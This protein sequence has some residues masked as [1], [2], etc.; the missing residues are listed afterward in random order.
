MF[1]GIP[2]VDRLSERTCGVWVLDV[3]SGQTV[4][5]VKFEEAV[6]EIFAIEV[7]PGVRFPDVINDNPDLLSNSYVLPDEALADV[8][9]SLCVRA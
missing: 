7:V 4:A 1:S 3:R 9:A 8:P 5:F 6:Q 2:L